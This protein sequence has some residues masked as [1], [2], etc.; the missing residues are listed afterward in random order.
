MSRPNTQSARRALPRICAATTALLLAMT[1]A[2]ALVNRQPA[3]EPAVHAF[4]ENLRHGEV[5][6][7]TLTDPEQA[8]PAERLLS[9][10]GDALAT[11]PQFPLAG[12]V[13]R[14][15]AAAGSPDGAPPGATARLRVRWRLPTGTWAYDTALLLRLVDDQWKVVWSPTALHPQL[16]D[17]HS[18]TVRWTVPER[19]PILSRDGA[20]LFEPRR[21]VTVHVQPRR[22][23]D[24]DR[25]VTVLDEA[26]QI[27]PE[28]LRQRV[29][30]ADPDHLVEVVT[31]RVEDYAPLRTTLHPVPGLVF[32]MGDRPL[33]P[34]RAFARALL[35]RVGPPTADVLDDVG[36]GFGPGD[37]LGL[38]GLQRQFQQ[39]LAGRPGMQIVTVDA[40]GDEVATLHHAPPVRGGALRTTLAPRFQ[41]AA[42]GALSDIDTTAALVAIRASTGEVLAVANG[43]DGGDHNH[44]FTGRYAPGS[45]FEVV[46]AAALLDHGVDPGR[47]V[48]CPP[49]ATV[50][51]R[52]FRNAGS[53]A[54]GHEMSFDTA[55]ARSCDTTLVQMSRDL[56]DDALTR[57]AQGF[58]F[59]GRWTPGVDAFRGAVP[60]PADA[61]ERAS[62]TIGQGRVLASPLLMASVAA[63]VANGTW[64]PPILLLGHAHAGNGPHR[65]RH[66]T[67]TA[68]AGMLRR[69]VTHGG[70]PALRAVPGRAVHAR[71]G[72]AQQGGDSRSRTHAWTIA[73]RGDV[74]VAVL[75]ED[76]GAGGRHA[77]AVAAGF[78]RRL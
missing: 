50:G 26:L 5:N 10:F 37:T 61:A 47:R 71:T 12:P 78:F 48:D 29:R 76:G 55:F 63:A 3:P 14:T 9:D 53:G 73:Y 45:T 16:A 19:G 75:I 72:I 57:T 6:P 20:P 42:D 46:S 49:T 38:S 4:V 39:H 52:M 66:T 28:P 8:E 7:A 62:A 11:T 35:G 36:P 74:A 65:L 25:V 27:A 54:L 77:A 21:V 56:A 68:L 1:T 18:P 51:G 22:V 59:G 13:E 31:L 23:R 30:S 40:D 15:S 41:T 60:T 32:K 70:V 34:S 24:L 69:A 64:R 43:P 17:G 33:T 67:A 44:A 2:C 58:G